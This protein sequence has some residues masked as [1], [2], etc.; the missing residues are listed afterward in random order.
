M[1]LVLTHRR[2]CHSVHVNDLVAWRRED[3]DPEVA[4]QDE[5]HDDAHLVSDSDRVGAGEP[6]VDPSYKAKL[7]RG[8]LVKRN[9]RYGAACRFAHS[10]DEQRAPPES[11]WPISWSEAA[12]KTR[13]CTDFAE[14]GF[15]AFGRY[16][17]WAH[18]EGELVAGAAPEKNE[19]EREEAAGPAERT[20]EPTPAKSTPAKSTP[21]GK[22]ERR[23]K[24]RTGGGKRSA[25]SGTAD[26]YFSTLPSDHVVD[27]LV[28]STSVLHDDSVDDMHVYR[29]AVF[30]EPDEEVHDDTLVPQASDAA[31]T[32]DIYEAQSS[33]AA[34]SWD[35]YDD[36]PA[37]SN[38]EKTETNES[39]TENEA[40]QTE[41]IADSAAETSEL[42]TA[43]TLSESTAADTITDAADDVSMLDA[44]LSPD[45][46]VIDLRAKATDAQPKAPP[47][48]PPPTL[49]VDELDT[50]AVLREV[51][52][53]V[54]ELEADHSFAAD[55]GAAGASADVGKGAMERTA[56]IGGAD[57]DL[58]EDD[59][60]IRLRFR[61][62]SA[63]IV[64]FFVVMLTVC[65][66]RRI[67][68]SRCT[69]C[70]RCLCCWASCCSSLH[71][72]PQSSLRQTTGR[73]TGGCWTR[74]ASLAGSGGTLHSE[75]C[76][77]QIDFSCIQLPLK[78]HKIE[79]DIRHHVYVFLIS[80]VNSMFHSLFCSSGIICLTARYFHDG[81]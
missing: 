57:T 29:G 74:A 67:W 1:I 41:P 37:E 20:A 75:F 81:S 5:V 32:W 46:T 52:G 48:L 25:N 78:Y 11:T 76:I 51:Q 34:A 60:E 3:R 40:T 24:S 77:V 73:L 19:V 30:G 39:N 28:P 23:G 63:F 8:H 38:A 26:L 36:A 61:H 17:H 55:A 58:T 21:R 45:A 14:S 10:A 79:L 13:L 69:A 31:S 44:T 22:K 62:L 49:A 42:T 4:D 12:T 68:S 71:S 6:R 72:C 27:H 16:C 64:T 50:A 47:S 56:P 70:S 80:Y 53:I 2:A 59:L 66:Q 33:D 9:C 65:A 35:I 18:G 15:C 43:T 7:C 54:A